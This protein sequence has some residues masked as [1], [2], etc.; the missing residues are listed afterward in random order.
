MYLLRIVLFGVLVSCN[1]N[2]KEIEEVKEYYEDGT[3]KKEG[4]YKDRKVHGKWKF[5]HP[6]GE[7]DFTQEY[8]NNSEQRK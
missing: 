1:M 4:Y 8:Q 2:N 7:L 3:L 6:N 5:Y